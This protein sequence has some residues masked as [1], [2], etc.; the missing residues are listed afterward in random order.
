MLSACPTA[1]GPLAPPLFP[2]GSCTAPRVPSCVPPP[3]CPVAESRPPA[4]ALWPGSPRA[5]TRGGRTPPQTAGVGELESP[6]VPAPGPPTAGLSEGAHSPG[7]GLHT[8]FTMEQ[9]S[10]LESSPQHPGELS[11][12]RGEPPSTV[13]SSPSTLE[14]SPQ[15]AAAWPPECPM[16][17]QETRLSQVQIRPGFRIGE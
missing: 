13:E 16:L 8:A 3:P 1:A 10:T 17:A 9:L 4:L 5:A 11:Q 6:G 12:H 2:G 7:L 14:S 15:Q